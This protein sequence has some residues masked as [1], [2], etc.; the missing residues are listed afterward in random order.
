MLYTEKDKLYV[1][2]DV[3]DR[4]SEPIKTLQDMMRHHNIVFILGNHDF[5]MYTL[6]KKLSVKIKADNYDKHLTLYD[7]RRKS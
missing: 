2:G 5:M 1:L 6:M 7:F 4:G 3:V